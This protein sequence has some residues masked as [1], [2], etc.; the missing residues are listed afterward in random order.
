M[1]NWEKV[2][3]LAGRY[4]YP[5]RKW[6]W[7]PILI[8][9]W[10]FRCQGKQIWFSLTKEK[11]KIFRQ[12][13]IFLLVMALIHFLIKWLLSFS[14]LP[15]RAKLIEKL[16]SLIT[17]AKGFLG[18]LPIILGSCVFAPII[19]ECLYRFFIFKI[20]G[21]K[22]PFSYLL[23]YFTFILAHWQVRGENF[24]SLFFQ[25][26]VATVGFIWIYKKSNWNL[27]YPIILHSLVNVLFIGITLINPDFP[28]I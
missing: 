19:E 11:K 8:V 9:F 7:M 28:L 1:E 14:H 3:E 25:Y 10:V 18:L 2:K 21:E 4:F 22:N 24:A 27:I 6:W 5:F 26:S 17:E 12:T 23:S 16:I 15:L 13:G 20:L